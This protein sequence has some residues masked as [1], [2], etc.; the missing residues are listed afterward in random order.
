MTIP[1]DA[2]PQKWTD[3]PDRPSQVSHIS[4]EWAEWMEDYV[5]ELERRI[6]SHKE[7]FVCR[8]KLTILE[9]DQWILDPDQ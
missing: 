6:A 9:P 1:K 2:R 7:H 3:D 5:E 4:S 8:L